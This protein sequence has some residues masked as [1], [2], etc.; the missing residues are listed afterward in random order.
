MNEKPTETGP[1]TERPAGAPEK[2]TVDG[3][4]RGQP[5]RKR[6][7]VDDEIAAALPRLPHASG[8][9]V[10]CYAYALSLPDVDMVRSSALCLRLVSLPCLSCSL[11]RS[12]PQQ[13]RDYEH[14]AGLRFAGFHLISSTSLHIPQ[15]KLCGTVSPSDITHTHT[16]TQHNRQGCCT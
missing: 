3:V 12:D 10:T 1:G 11:I 4:V 15:F 16:H 14:F 13:G 5:P 6:S 7:R 2:R 8:A 9:P